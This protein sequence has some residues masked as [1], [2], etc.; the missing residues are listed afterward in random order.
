MGIF[1]PEDRFILVPFV[2]VLFVYD[3]AMMIE[4]MAG[5]SGAVHGMVHDASPFR[6]SED[7]TAIEHHGKLL[8]QGFFLVYISVSPSTYIVEPGIEDTI[9]LDLNPSLFF[10]FQRNEIACLKW[11][12]ESSWEQAL[13]LPASSDLVDIQFRM[14]STCLDSLFLSFTELLPR[15]EGSDR[16][17]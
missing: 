11:G 12:M 6:F 5:K 17:C 13:I 2:D 1:Q 8:E 14:T 15:N 4:C 9:P 3:P 16:T 7:D 10:F